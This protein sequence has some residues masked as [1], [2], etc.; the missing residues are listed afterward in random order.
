MLDNAAR[1]WEWLE[2]GA[3]VFVCGDAQRMAR[4]VDS[5]LQQI[6]VEHGARARQPMRDPISRHSPRAGR[7]QRDVY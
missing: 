7:Y 5:T 6:V 2:A 3:H 1:L 4:D